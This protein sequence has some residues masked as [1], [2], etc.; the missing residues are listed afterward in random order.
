MG[1]LRGLNSND[2][3]LGGGYIE[4]GSRDSFGSAFGLD[5]LMIPRGSHFAQGMHD[6]TVEA[7]NAF[8][9]TLPVI[10]SGTWSI[11]PRAIGEVV[12]MVR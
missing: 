7:D 1:M 10:K 12:W 8:F 3:C 6:N 4:M 5:N 9:N 2:D 11:V